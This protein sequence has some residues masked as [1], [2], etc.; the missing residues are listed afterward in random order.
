MLVHEVRGSIGKGPGMQEFRPE[1]RLTACEAVAA[2]AADAQ[3]SVSVADLHGFGVAHATSPSTSPIAWDHT[4][5]ATIR[6][7]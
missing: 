7:S 3:P 2:I 1:Q 4:H 6:S 5:F